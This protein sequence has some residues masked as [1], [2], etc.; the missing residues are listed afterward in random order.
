MDRFYKLN[1]REY[2]FI[3]TETSLLLFSF[4]TIQRYDKINIT[5]NLLC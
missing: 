5:S 2:K 3:L 4:N 1:E